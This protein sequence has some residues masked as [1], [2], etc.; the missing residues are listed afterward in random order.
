MRVFSDEELDDLTSCPK[1]I[2]DAPR[3]EM[4]LD[5]KMKRNEM[6]LKSANG[7][8]QFRVFMRQS[9][10]FPENFTIGLVYLPNE[11]PGEVILL[12]CNGQHGGTKAHP[13]HASFHT[14]RMQAQDINAGIKEPRLVEQTGDYDSFG[15]AVR[16]FCQRIRLENG[17][18]HFPGLNQRRLFP[19]EEAQL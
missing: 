2:V 14:H 5:G 9:D 6:T 3:R 19:D 10:D 12:R 17:D 7:K 8:H 13:H 11:E 15:A 4:R 18:Q 16:A 1:Q